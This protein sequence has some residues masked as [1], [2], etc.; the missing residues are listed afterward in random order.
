MVNVYEVIPAPSGDAPRPADFSGYAA[1]VS[2]SSTGPDSYAFRTFQMM[3]QGQRR[4]HS[5]DTP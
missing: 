2:R 5:V 1:S 3:S 4:A